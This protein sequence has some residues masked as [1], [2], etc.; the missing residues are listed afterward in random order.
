MTLSPAIGFFTCKNQN[1]EEV[2]IAISRVGVLATKVEAVRTL[3]A[4]TFYLIDAQPFLLFP[5][6]RS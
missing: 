4:R 6:Q 1:L 3:L 5:L 2:A